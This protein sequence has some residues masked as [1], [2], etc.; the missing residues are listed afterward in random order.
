MNV[1]NKF[2]RGFLRRSSIK[3]GRKLRPANR[4]VT[5]S[6]SHH[7]T[8][9]E[10]SIR[11]PP[12]GE[13][14]GEIGERY[15]NQRTTL[16]PQYRISRED[17]INDDTGAPAARRELGIGG[18]D[19]INN[20][21]WTVFLNKG[22]LA[23]GNNNVGPAGVLSL[24]VDRARPTTFSACR[25]NL[26]GGHPVLVPS[27]SLVPTAK[28]IDA[29]NA[30]ISTIAVVTTTD[31]LNPSGNVLQARLYGPCHAVRRTRLTPEIGCRSTCWRRRSKSRS[32]R[33][34]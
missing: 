28:R 4:S 19:A 21:L 25:P 17:W 3:P 8:D 27:I 9:R 30:I 12:T 2:V 20:E 10:P 13:M 7:L 5:L 34:S 22:L 29:L 32:S 24:G 1:A 33:A 31:K 26:N 16:R 15:P 18:G 6:K 11:V 14:S 23:A